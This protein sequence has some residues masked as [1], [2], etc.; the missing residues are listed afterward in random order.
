MTTREGFSSFCVDVKLLSKLRLGGVLNLSCFSFSRL[1]HVTTLASTVDLSLH[2]VCTR[3]GSL[4]FCWHCVS[5]GIGIGIG[6]VAVS[7]PF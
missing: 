3:S 5:F 6:R 1:V 4:C 2:V 7:L